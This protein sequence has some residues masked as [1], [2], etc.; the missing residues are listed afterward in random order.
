[1]LKLMIIGAMVTTAVS[2]GASKPQYA[3]VG[4]SDHVSQALATFWIFANLT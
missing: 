1:M 4:N 2:L 3:E